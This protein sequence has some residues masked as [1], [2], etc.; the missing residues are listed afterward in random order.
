M[1]KEGRDSLG[2]EK[3]KGEERRK[4]G[5]KTTNISQ[6]APLAH[7]NSEYAFPVV[8]PMIVE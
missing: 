4:P 5:Y 1:F 6:Y 2:K 7:A 3:R 8:N